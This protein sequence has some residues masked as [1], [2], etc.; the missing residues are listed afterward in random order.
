M[1]ATAASSRWSVAGVIAAR[2]A[3][4]SLRGMGGYIAASAAVIAAA[5][6]LLI[7]VRAVESA[8]VHVLAH[9][10]KAPLAAALLVLTSFLALSAAVSAA[11]DRESG[12][13]EVLFYGPVDEL[14]YV[15]GKIAGPLVAYLAFLPL[16]LA[17]LLLLSAMTGFALTPTV[18]VGLMISVL[19]VAEVLSFGVLLSVGTSRV[20]TAVL[21]LVGVIAFLLGVTVAYG[22]VLLVPIADPASPMLPLRDALAT[23][24][25]G[26][27][28]ISPFAHLERIVGSAITGAWQAALVSLAAAIG[29]TAVMLAGAA[30]WLRLRGVHRRGE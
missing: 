27:T 30:Y 1:T 4:A 21:I 18:L 9:P 3:R 13:L 20:R 11:R 17:A 19:P 28:W 15:L 16:L 6:F 2:E 29:G 10:F 22:I 8:G 25:A 23:L 14:S 26:V 12:T 7:D 24:N 5:W